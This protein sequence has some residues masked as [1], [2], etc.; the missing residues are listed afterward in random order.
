MPSEKLDVFELLKGAALKDQLGHGLLFVSP[1]LKSEAF[2]EGLKNFVAF[3]MCTQKEGTQPCGNCDSCVAFHDSK[4]NEGVHPDLFWIRPESKTGYNVD[5]IKDLRTGMGLARGIAAEKIV[6]IEDAEDLGGGGGASANALLKL[7][8]EPRPNTRLVLTST[9]PEGILPTIRSRCQI[10]RIPLPAG[11]KAQS[12]LSPEAL[13][14]WNPLWKWIDVGLPGLDWPLVSLPADLDTFFKEREHATEE[15][16]GVFLESWNRAREVLPRL[17]TL[18]SQETLHW[19][20]N[21][22]KMLFSLKFHGQGAL[23]WSAFKSRARV[24]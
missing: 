4:N 7:L 16:R 2:S 10:F 3:V 21:F 1:S 24:V 17:D 11:E 6:V 14:S 8:E 9:R 22:E 18:R 23:Q 15:L 13:E 5:Q 12:P 20:E 19:F